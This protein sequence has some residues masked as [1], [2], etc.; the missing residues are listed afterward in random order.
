MAAAAAAAADN[1]AD[2]AFVENTVSFVVAKL[3]PLS[4]VVAVF[5]GKIVAMPPVL[6][7]AVFAVAAVASIIIGAC[8]PLS[9]CAVAVAVGVVPGICIRFPL[10]LIICGCVGN[11]SLIVCI[12]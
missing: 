6:F 8:W 4:I 5:V 3:A 7:G 11:E 1:A 2:V 9:D 12:G 10:I